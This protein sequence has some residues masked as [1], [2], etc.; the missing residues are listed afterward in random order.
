[1][2][3]LSLQEKPLSKTREMIEF[4]V[5]SLA[6]V[7]APLL[8]G[9]PADA[10]GVIVNFCLV[11]AALNFRRWEVILIILLPSLGAVARNY[12]FGAKSLLPVLTLPIVWIGNA[13]LVVV[14]KWLYL[15]LKWNNWL[16]LAIAVI[17][18]ALVM[19]GIAALM[20]ALKILPPA[21]PLYWQFGVFQLYTAAIGGVLAY[22]YAML[23]G[24][25]FRKKR[26]P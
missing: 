22:G 24:V 11:L 23:A 15:K 9:H 7:L 12:L 1:M 19:F 20:I 16:V 2:N 21:K 25:V 26:K 3:L 18:K 17:V 8:I 14:I 13:A 4:L 10:V 6:C 5:A